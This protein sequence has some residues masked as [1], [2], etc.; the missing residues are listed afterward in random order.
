MERTD[1]LDKNVPKGEVRC[2]Y[3]GHPGK[4]P[5]K[6]EIKNKCLPRGCPWLMSKEEFDQW[7]EQKNVHFIGSY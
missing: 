5:G 2:G 6:K 4:I 1:G 3:I 7:C